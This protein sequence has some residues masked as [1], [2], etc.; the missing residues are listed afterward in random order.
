MIIDELIAVLGYDLKGQGNL[1]RFNA[2]MERAA[3]L[4][5]TMSAAI[6]AAGA[7]AS[8]AL[9]TLGKGVINVSSEFEGYQT[10]L[11]TI[12]GSAEKAK[13]SMDWIA[14]F[15]AKTPYELAGVTE[16]FIKLRAYGFDPMDGSLQTLGDTASAMNKPLMQAV[17]AFADAATGEF[18]RLKE[19]GIKAKQKGEQVTFTWQQNGKE[20]TKVVKKNGKDITKFL[21]DTF[22]SRFNGAM[23]RQSKTWKG[24]M[25]NLSDSW[26]MFQKRI[27]DAGFFEHVKR[28]LGGIL[29]TIGELDANGTLSRWAKRLSDALVS[30]FD[31]L[32][33]VITR[34]VR[35]LGTIGDLL[36][37][38][39]QK[40]GDFLRWI[41]DGEIDL[42]N[43]Q[44]LVAFFGALLAVLNPAWAALAGL[45]LAVDDFLTYLRGGKSVIGDMIQSLSELIP[46]AQKAMAEIGTAIA[47]MDWQAAGAAIGTAI[48]NGI[49]EAFKAIASAASSVDWGALGK[50]IGS[51]IDFAAIG[52]AWVAALK[53]QFDLIRG[54]GDGIVVALANLDWA[55][56]GTTWVN[57]LKAQ[58]SFVQ[59]AFDG[60][61]K[62]IG[63]AIIT[64][65][66]GVD[67]SGL[68]EKIKAGIVTALTALPAAVIALITGGDYSEI[69]KK[70]GEG[71]LAGL[72][73]M[74]G[75]IKEWFAGLLP[76]W[77]SDFFTWEAEK[78]G[79]LKE[80]ATKEGNRRA[81]MES[82]TTPANQNTP[83]IQQLFQ[84]MQGNTAKTG[85][86]A[87]VQAVVNDNSNRSVT[88]N[89]SVSLTVQQVQQAASA[90]AAS[91]KDAVSSKLSSISST[92]SRKVMSPWSR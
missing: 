27:G 79:S 1:D 14:Q 34:V 2:G 36:D 41:S 43:W 22:G 11:E 51:S 8:A 55:S 88:T 46:S 17:E 61:S 60:L 31:L 19:F 92:P 83:G 47:N 62:S 54:L 82:L 23:I 76:G 25:S 13:S 44:A 66:D 40:I 21:M 37:T 85:A 84:N 48:V 53:A 35:H 4:A 56:I 58:F 64:W 73:S 86:S 30:G 16:A 65:F 57:A 80:K 77:A 26:S 71:I 10:S 29:D 18:E 28:R 70:I 32:D 59:G 91:V 38:A 45:A 7:V 74:G 89:T 6:V 78:D 12:E 20:M 72:Q 67:W 63:D 81:Q 15:A 3:S 24:M 9:F 69:G 42:D 90:A 87:A 50:S 52:S 68:G 49:S 33:G 5:R 75:A 39:G